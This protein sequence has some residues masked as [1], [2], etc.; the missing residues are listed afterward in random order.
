MGNFD[1]LLQEPKFID[2]ASVAQT[3]EKVLPIDPPT[4]ALTC[5]RAMELAIKWMYSVDRDLQEPYQDNLVTLMNTDSFRDIVDLKLWNRLEYI[6]RVGNL[7]AH[8]SP[9]SRKNVS[10]DQALLALEFL[11][12]FFQF[13]AY[14]YSQIEVPDTPF[15][16]EKLSALAAPKPG[17]PLMQEELEQ[18]RRALQEKENELKAFQQKYAQAE[19]EATALRKE[20]ADSF[21]IHP[22]AMSEADTRRA[23]ID[24]MLAE[25]GWVRGENWLDEYPIAEM[26]TASGQ[27]FADYV[28]FGKDGKPLA[29]I[30]A[31][32]TSRDVAVG[33]EQAKLYANSLEKRFSSRPII[34]LTNGFET[35]IIEDQKGGYPERTVSSIYSRQDLEEEFYKLQHKQ[36]LINAVLN[37][38]I[39][40]RYYQLAAVKAICEAF[41]K[42]NRRKALLV[43]A[44]GSGKTRTIISLVDVLLRHGWIKNFLFLADRNSLV[45]QAKKAFGGLLPDL[46]TTNLAE[47]DADPK[48]RGVFSTYQTMIH[49]ID[50]VKD[51]AGH[52]LFT[53]GHFD[54]IIVDEAHRSLYNKYKAIFDYFDALLV[55]MTATP[56]DEID[57][58]TYSVFD[59]EDGVPTYN[60]D[61]T[62]AVED[63]FLVPYH[64]VDCKLKLMQEGIHYNNLSDAEKREYEATFA[65]ENG[66]WPDSIDGKALN[67][68]IFNKDTIKQ[69]LNILMTMGLRVHQNS[70][71]G[72]TIIFARSHQHAEEILKIWKEL[73]PERGDDYCAIID[74]YI[75]YAQSV[76]DKFSDETKLP[77][78]A[79]S[80]DMLDTGVDV[81][82]ILNLVFFKPVLS[83]AKFWQ[84][85]GRGTR[86]CKNLIDG[87]DKE[88]FYI[89]DLCGNFDFFNVNPNGIEGVAVITLAQGVFSLQVELLFKLQKLDQQTP[90]LQIIR[91]EL[92]QKVLK[93]LKGLAHDR[94]DVRLQLKYV[95]AFQKKQD[96]DAMTFQD[97]ENL[98][99]HVAPL[100]ENED[101]D[102]EASR[103]DALLY[104]LEIQTLEGNVQKR[105]VSDLTRKVNALNKLGTIADVKKKKPF[106]DTLVN[107]DYIAKAGVPEWEKIRRELRDL[108]KLIPRKKETAYETDFKDTL[109]G[110][111][112]PSITDPQ[113]EPPVPE[114]YEKKVKYYL[115]QHEDIPAIKK[116]RNNEPLQQVD[117]DDLEDLLWHRLGTEE[118]Y[119]NLYQNRPLGEFVRS[120]VGMDKES[121]N[122]AFA[123]YINQENLNENQ[124]Y[125]VKQL[126]DY[127]S[128]NGM[129]TDDSLLMKPPFSN[130]GN[131]AALFGKNMDI[132][133]KIQSAVKE[134]NRNG[135][136]I[137]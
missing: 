17:V 49:C 25:A 102:F 96:F 133:S 123:K 70:D 112:E 95:D 91:K 40:G 24:V 105:T 137:Q 8:V 5:R 27:G 60:Y 58:N 47:S 85:I 15:S 118:Q 99:K 127:L 124:I 83:R 52:R 9:Q 126:I 43:M 10:R 106:I 54:L 51:D 98:Q 13:I 69:A 28:L 86:T 68:K 1:Y 31:K 80:V 111:N 63:K 116:L 134:I 3:A 132:W 41:D 120:L 109:L 29:V 50:A 62:K 44:T 32:K 110:I 72:K 117:L 56:R 57:R 89:F 121:L 103:F 45:L 130:K 76:L 46:T 59:L 33:R 6:R 65:D 115:E 78:I 73:Y 21:K 93:K 35:R 90:E 128:V 87:K 14:S 82:S 12:S 100:M 23:Y 131:V 88:Q 4:C 71:I 39:A 64:V 36:P 136:I 113:P 37:Q 75:K 114:N 26:P 34:F 84:M 30:E 101:K 61:L 74:N 53:C 22:E 97:M 129:L 7:A 19:A 94:F 81:P 77:Q 104:Q 48:A 107:T 55:G 67:Q 92:V 42:R 122:K 108:L 2:F 79:I 125:F 11:H 119:H 18:A 16:K 66:K 135:S 38:D 20:K